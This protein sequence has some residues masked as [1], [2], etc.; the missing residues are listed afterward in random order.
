MKSIDNKIRKNKFSFLLLST[1]TVLGTQMKL[2]DGENGD[3][4]IALDK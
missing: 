3:Y 4:M 2:Q 1:E